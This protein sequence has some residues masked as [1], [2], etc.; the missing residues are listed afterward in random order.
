MW[1]VCLAEDEDLFLESLL[2]KKYLHK[3]LFCFF[4]LLFFLFFAGCQEKPFKLCLI[5][6]PTH[7]SGL[8]RCVL[9]RNDFGN[10]VGFNCYLSIVWQNLPISDE[11]LLQS[12][13][14]YFKTGKKTGTSKLA[15]RLLGLLL[16]LAH[17]SAPVPLANADWTG[18]ML[19]TTILKEAEYLWLA[20]LLVYPSSENG[21][22]FR[23]PLTL[24]KV[25][26]FSAL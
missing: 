5:N 19:K 26:L 24:W 15:Q 12:D 13:F 2:L 23:H 22:F 14:T 7:W 9:K 3:S 6:I 1:L 21:D 11:I 10:R 18:Q 16:V 4:Y 8:F 25:V 20:T 17:I